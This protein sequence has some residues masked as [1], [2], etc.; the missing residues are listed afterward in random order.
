VRVLILSQYY[1]PEP[2]LK[3]S[4]LAEELVRR[5]HEVQVLTGIPN[6]PTGALAEGYRLRPIRRES[7]GG[8]PVTRVFEIPYHGGSAAGRIANYVSFMLAAI[9][10]VP[11]VARPD[12][13]YVWHPPLTLGVPASILGRIYG[14][15]FVYDVQDIW[16]DEA[17]MSGILKEGR[18]A[19]VL[20]WL[21][22]FV[23]RRADHLIVITEAARTNLLAKGVPTEKISVL[24]HWIYKDLSLVTNE[25]HRGRGRQLLQV[26]DEFVVTFAGNIG[27]LQKLE[28]LLSA[29]AELRDR[30]L[31]T[32]RIIGD[33]AERPRLEA[34]A[35]RMNLSNV[36]FM[37]ARPI[38]QMPDLLAASDALL[39]HLRAGPMTDLVLPA[40]TLA[41]LLA[42]RPLI[43]AMTGAAAELVKECGAGLVIPPE[44]PA[45]LARAV[46]ELFALPAPDRAAMG[47][48][49]QRCAETRF[50][51]EAL[52]G[53]HEELLERVASKR[54]TRVSH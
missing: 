19:E 9:I 46:L 11:F 28:T 12:V 18:V 47:T 20:R 15:P 23:Y 32:F 29:A 25:E 22:R 37:G 7:L 17:I 8:V 42:A 44:D 49:G 26:K 16:P 21:E 45:A 50:S 6:Y 1:R 36:T 4:E 35:R 38:A 10:A 24:P 14:A 43:V 53:R 34:L 40:K 31:I 2:V 41:Y 52:I 30:P 3:P 5:G 54:R 48:R 39:V 51:R 27:Y 33:G 13:I